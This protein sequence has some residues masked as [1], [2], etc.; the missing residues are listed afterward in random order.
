MARDAALDGG[1]ASSSAA[2]RSARKAAAASAE[3]AVH[4]FRA[5][6]EGWKKK[7]YDLAYSLGSDRCPQLG[8]RLAAAAPA[9][10]ALLLDEPVE[11]TDV[12]RR[13]VALH[14]V[15]EG[16]DIVSA[17]PAE[18]NSAQRVGALTAPF[19][20]SGFRETCRPTLEKAA[21]SPEMAMGTLI[22]VF[23]IVGIC[24]F[25]VL[26]LC[27]VWHCCFLVRG[28]FSWFG[29]I[30][31]GLHGVQLSGEIYGVIAAP[32]LPPAKAPPAQA[33][34]G[35][36]VAMNGAGLPVKPAPPTASGSD[37]LLAKAPPLGS[38]SDPLPAKA[39]PLQVKPP[40]PL[41]ARQEEENGPIL[42]P[43]HVIVLLRLLVAAAAP[44]I[45]KAPPAQF[46][47]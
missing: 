7:Y 33:S 37:A 10:E 43:L 14:S 44:L 4:H 27:V 24:W 17:S 38:G 5:E 19:L 2:R 9:L 18:L 40:P 1:K 34:P 12:L 41:G 8:L 35:A 6:A 15:A 32:K 26:A 39:A 36:A 47:R 25:W 20:C 29:L 42:P 3:R 13:N 45:R 23:V 30:R 11:H 31:C 21:S 46:A 28:S 22:V 16:I